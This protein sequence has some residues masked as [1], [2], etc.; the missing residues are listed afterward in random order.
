MKYI[1]INIYCTLSVLDVNLKNILVNLL[2]VTDKS[3]GSMI[4]VPLMEF[5]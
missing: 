5:L 4:R 2:A 1:C 3:E